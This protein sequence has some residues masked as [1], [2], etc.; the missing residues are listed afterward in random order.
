MKLRT[1]LVIIVGV[2]VALGLLLASAL[3]Y[4][5]LRN[6]LLDR[7]DDQLV[8]V[9][10]LAARVLEAAIEGEPIEGTPIE[11]P[12]RT[13]PFA[14][15]T[16][17]REPDGTLVKRIIFGYDPND[18]VNRPDL[19]ETLP[20]DQT[21]PFTVGSIDDASYEFRVLVT[22]LPSGSS[23]TVAIPLEEINDTL[24][25]LLIIEAVVAASLL[26]ATAGG[27]WWLVRR[28][29]RPL[30]RMTEAAAKIAGGD[31]AQRV[32]VDDARTEVGTLGQA[33]NQMLEHIEK[34]FEVQRESEDR[35]RRFLADASH[36]LRTP[37]TSIRGYAELF[38]RGADQRPEDLKL[39]MRRIEDEAARMGVLVEDLLLLASVDRTR[40]LDMDPV[41]LS[42]LVTDAAADARALDP[43]RPI[44]VRI[45]GPVTVR[46]DEDRLRQAVTNLVGNALS[47][48]PPD[49]PIELAAR[50]DDAVAIIDVS[51]GGPG[52]DDD[53][54]QHAFERFWRADPN[55]SRSSGGVGLGL[56]IV[57]AIARAHGGS[58]TVENRP[59]GGA[60]F[61]IRLPVS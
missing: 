51:D 52:L 31:L 25:R 16:E 19:P 10:P 9:Q 42:A 17:L 4:V 40:P 54:L 3:T 30:E 38:R 56:A 55:R 8:T 57:D 49:A 35:L 44:E 48:T 46:G 20:A 15:V 45:P 59:E 43:Q 28:E 2:L 50:T 53:A 27:A 22:R 26:A 33:L 47:H 32:E 58:V 37:L 41:D 18:P 34:A 12:A 1:R 60:R 36:E 11:G 13:L 39:A 23:L 29:L 6:F 7:L 14:S 5:A 24:Q 61:S 21:E